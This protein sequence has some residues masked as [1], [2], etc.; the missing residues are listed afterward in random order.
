ML[1]T[2]TKP[3]EVRVLSCTLEAET[4][5][6]GLGVISAAVVTVLESDTD[7]I[8]TVP[9]T[10]VL[11]VAEAIILTYT[12]CPTDLVI[13]EVYPEPL[14]VDTEALPLAVTVT[15]TSTPVTT[16]LERLLLLVATPVTSDP[17]EN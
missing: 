6:N 5:L 10:A 11:V 7:P 12:V 9:V 2:W 14:V 1:F 16:K 15:E 17:I 3:E 4:K 8:V 13:L